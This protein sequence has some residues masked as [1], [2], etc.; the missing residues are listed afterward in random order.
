MQLVLE[1]E[2]ELELQLEVEAEEAE[3]EEEEE[4]AGEDRAPVM[5]LLAPA[6]RKALVVRCRHPRCHPPLLE[7]FDVSAGLSGQAG[8]FSDQVGDQVV[9]ETE[10]LV[11]PPGVDHPWRYML[12]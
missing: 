4:E 11:D 7:Q 1:L 8:G 2:L 3:E 12:A 9:A 5:E 6:G 10:V